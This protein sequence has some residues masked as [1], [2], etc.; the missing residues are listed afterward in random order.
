[1]DADVIFGDLLLDFKAT[2]T[3]SIVGRGE[4]W[5]LVGYALADADDHFGIRQVGVGGVS[6]AA[7]LDDR[8]RRPARAPGW[9]VGDAR[10]STGRVRRGA[11][12]ASRPSAKESRPGAATSPG[13]A[14]L[15]IRRARRVPRWR[16]GL[17]I[18]SA[19]RASFDPM[20]L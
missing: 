20:L 4:L 14:V 15:A 7:L 17:A 6:V 5:Q 12:A 19:P 9:S 8:N 13:R 18:G 11:A 16:I 10:P 3:T 2:S 1:V